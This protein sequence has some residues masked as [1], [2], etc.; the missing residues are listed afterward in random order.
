MT[1]RLSIRR[2]AVPVALALLFLAGCT[3]LADLKPGVPRGMREDGFDKTTE[4]LSMTVRGSLD[5]VWAATMRG[6]AAIVAK[7]RQ[8]RIVSTDRPRAV[9]VE[10]LDFLGLFPNSFTGIFLTPQGEAVLV[11]VS[12][13]NQTRMQVTEF[14]PTEGDWLRAIQRA[15]SPQE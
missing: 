8:T 13:I 4:G 11:E 14:G 2:A 3:S 15:L 6:A 9:R 1:D 10:R 7:D 5:E 12:K